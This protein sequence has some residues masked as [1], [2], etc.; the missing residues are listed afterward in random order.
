MDNNALVGASILHADAAVA[1]LLSCLFIFSS[2]G[3]LYLSVQVTVFIIFTLLV[4]FTF[5]SPINHC[6]SRHL[7]RHIMTRVLL[8]SSFCKQVMSCR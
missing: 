4:I 3:F 5:L 1:R 8:S 6:V 7:S 2:A